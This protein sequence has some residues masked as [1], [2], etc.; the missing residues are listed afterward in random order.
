L[1]AVRYRRSVRWN[2]DLATSPQDDL[3]AP[4][5]ADNQIADGW[6]D[7]GVFSRAVIDPVMLS[8]AP[9]WLR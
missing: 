3:L 8:P 5:I 1:F 9:P 4:G 7:D 2:T 6:S